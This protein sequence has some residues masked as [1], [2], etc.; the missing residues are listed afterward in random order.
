MIGQEKIKEWVDLNE[1]NFPHFI[2]LIAPSG[3]GKRTVAKYI[4]S[5]LSLIYDECEI[6]TEAVREVIDNAYNTT[7]N[8]MYCFADADMMKVQAKNALLKITEEPP[9]N[10]YF[11]LTLCDESN[12]LDTL[13]SRANV[14]YLQH[15][16]GNEKRYYYDQVGGNGL[17]RKHICDTSDSLDD[18]NKLIEYG[19]DFLTYVKLVYENIAEVE[20]ANAFKS[21][22]KLALKT[23][24]GY[25]VGLFWKVFNKLCL[26]EPTEKNMKAVLIT[27]NSLHR[28]YKMGVNKQQLYDMWVLDIREVWI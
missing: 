11:C 23:D 12:L 15:Y 17:D 8:I 9:R 28:L 21:S 7:S 18:I 2:V 13:K 24:E 27:C 1:N 14:L 22:N 10:A 4:A 20:P 26:E 25:D 19:E 6:R 5:K 3:Y 16:S